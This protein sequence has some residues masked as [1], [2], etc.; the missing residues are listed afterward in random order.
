M[1]QELESIAFFNIYLLKVLIGRK[2]QAVVMN[3]TPLGKDLYAIQLGNEIDDLRID[4]TFLT[5]WNLSLT[6]L[7]NKKPHEKY[8]RQIYF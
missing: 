2:S 1:N 8:D 3:N 6:T 7:Y 4:F 5:T